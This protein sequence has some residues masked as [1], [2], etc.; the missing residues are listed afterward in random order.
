MN[1]KDFIGCIRKEVISQNLKIYDDLLGTQS[2][3]IADETWNKISRAFSTMSEEQRA[4]L[5]LMARQAMID[6]SSNIL[7]ILDGSS[8]LENYREDFNLTYGAPKTKLNGD[9]QDHFLGS[10]EDSP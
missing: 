1:A 7:G 4:A 9:L 5:R 10:I 3:R 2:D 6:T 8:C